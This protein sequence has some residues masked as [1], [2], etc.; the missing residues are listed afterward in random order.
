MENIL[1][2]FEPFEGETGA[3]REYRAQIVCLSV[4]IA[5]ALSQF[6]N[7]AKT[8]DRDYT[9]V[10]DRLESVQKNLNAATVPKM[11]R[12]AHKFI[13]NALESYLTGLNL[14]I[15]A[16][17]KEDAHGIYRAARYIVEG[18]NFI[19]IAK[20]RMYEAVEERLSVVH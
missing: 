5:E 3:E 18:N 17:E 15:T 10:R 13:V 11:Y 2:Q 8:K 20:N 12:N 9:G 4:Q 16:V 1:D 14:V 7:I 6:E 19:C